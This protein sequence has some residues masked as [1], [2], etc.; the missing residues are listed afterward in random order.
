M[1]IVVRLICS[2]II[3]TLLY[4]CSSNE[5]PDSLLDAYVSARPGI[6]DFGELSV[7]TLTDELSEYLEIKG[8][9]FVGWEQVGDSFHF[10]VK[11]N[12]NRNP[13]AFIFQPINDKYVLAYLSDD[14]RPYGT[15]QM[16]RMIRMT[17][18]NKK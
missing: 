9:E 18:L 11:M 8:A 17:I 4:G 12:P 10:K 16:I 1:P 7:R 5:P 6:D 15:I 13:I 2:V 14:K 3:T